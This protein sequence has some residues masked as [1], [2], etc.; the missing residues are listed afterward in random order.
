MLSLDTPLF[1][2]I[3][4]RHHR[5]VGFPN[6]NTQSGDSMAQDN[7]SFLCSECGGFQSNEIFLTVIDAPDRVKRI[8]EA[9]KAYRAAS[10]G[11]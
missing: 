4:V 2:G 1:P 9:C 11:C 5:A 6:G 8:D 7:V 3:Y 10:R